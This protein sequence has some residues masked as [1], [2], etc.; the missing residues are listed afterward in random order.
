MID[1][2]LLSSIHV[3]I[4]RS[5]SYYTEIYIY[6]YV[7]IIF[8]YIYIHREKF[9]S[10]YDM[11]PCDI[12]YQSLQ[13]T[14]HFAGKYLRYR[15]S[16]YPSLN[17][18]LGQTLPQNEAVPMRLVVL[19]MWSQWEYLAGNNP[20]LCEAAILFKWRHLHHANWGQA[21]K[22]CEAETCWQQKMLSKAPH[23]VQWSEKPPEISSCYSWIPAGNHTSFDS[24]CVNLSNK[25]LHSPNLH[26][27]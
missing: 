4:S 13:L 22:M 26:L 27:Q 12:A 7:Y 6:M 18:V 23:Q 2:A 24:G 5:Y 17:G 21:R 19:V 9:H 25:K 16:H 3:Y 10:G 14:F 20:I 15:S 8:I 11:G 1:I